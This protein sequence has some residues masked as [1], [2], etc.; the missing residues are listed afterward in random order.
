MVVHSQATNQEPDCVFD[1]TLDSDCNSYISGPDV[2]G[3]ASCLQPVLYDDGPSSTADHIPGDG[4]HLLK[5]D[6]PSGDEDENG[7]DRA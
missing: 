6:D 5:D 7:P 1:P 2:A 4:G 3:G